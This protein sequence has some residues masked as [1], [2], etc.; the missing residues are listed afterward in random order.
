MSDRIVG[1]LGVLTTLAVPLPGVTNQASIALRLEAIHAMAELDLA[2]VSCMRADLGITNR[3]APRRSGHESRSH[4]WPIG[5]RSVQL[6]A[7]A[8][9]HL[10]PRYERGMSDRSQLRTLSI[11]CLP[12]TPT[13]TRAHSHF[14]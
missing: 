14:T 12:L 4:S 11:L 13:S 3:R 8:H 2:L 6:I 9:K 10:S 5:W 1:L 7:K